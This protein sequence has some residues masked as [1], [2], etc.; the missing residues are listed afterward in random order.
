MT[1]PSASALDLD[2]ALFQLNA[3]GLG[4]DGGGKQGAQHAD[5]GVRRGQEERSAGRLLG[6]IRPQQTA[7]RNTFLPPRSLAVASRSRQ[8]S[9]GIGVQLQTGGVRILDDGKAIMTAGL[10]RLSGKQILPGDRRHI[11]SRGR[12]HLS[13]ARHL[14]QA[15]DGS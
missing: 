11:V 3:G 8:L 5:L 14:D 4:R 9:H 7:Q 1:L 10:Q 2:A 13:L 12:A 15:S 6:H